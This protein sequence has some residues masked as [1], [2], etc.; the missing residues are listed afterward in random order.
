M[1]DIEGYEYRADDECTQQP[2]ALQ[3]KDIHSLIFK[4]LLVI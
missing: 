4:L 2:Q 3:L 1:E